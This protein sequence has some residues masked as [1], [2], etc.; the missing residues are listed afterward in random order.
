[1]SLLLKER[2]SVPYT[3]VPGIISLIEVTLL[4]SQLYFTNELP[5]NP[6]EF[7]YWL[8]SLTS[9]YQL[10]LLLYFSCY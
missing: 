6:A 3:L 2:S 4:G 5:L 8:W 10:A 9:S 7:V 1:M